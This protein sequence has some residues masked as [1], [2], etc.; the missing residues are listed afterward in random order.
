MLNH[1]FRLPAVGEPSIRLLAEEWINRIPAAAIPQQMRKEALKSVHG[2][3]QQLILTDPDCYPQPPPRTN[4][5]GPRNLH[6]LLN[7]LRDVQDRETVITR[8]E[9]AKACG[10]GWTHPGLNITQPHEKIDAALDSE[11]WMNAL[12]ELADSWGVWQ[13]T[14]T[15]TKRKRN[16]PLTP[17]DVCIRS[18]GLRLIKEVHAIR[19]LTC[20]INKKRS[21]AK[22]LDIRCFIPGNDDAKFQFLCQINV[23]A[24]ER[25][26]SLLNMTDPQ[27]RAQICLGIDI[28][29]L[30]H[31]DWTQGKFT[32]GQRVDIRIMN[33]ALDRACGKR[34]WIETIDDRHGGPAQVTVRLEEDDRSPVSCSARDIQATH[35][36][37]WSGWWVRGQN[38]AIVYQCIVCDHIHSRPTVRMTIRGPVC[39]DCQG[40]K[41]RKK[42]NLASRCPLS[43]PDSDSD[44]ESDEACD[45]DSTRSY[46]RPGVI[47]RTLIP[48][49][50]GTLMQ[51]TTVS[52]DEIRK[53]IRGMLQN[54][55]QPDWTQCWAT[56]K[57]VGFPLVSALDSDSSSELP[58]GGM[59]PQLHPCIAHFLREHGQKKHSGINSSQLDDFMS[60]WVH[61]EDMP[62]PNA[63]EAI[64]TCPCPWQQY[65]SPPEHRDP[66]YLPPFGPPPRSPQL[67]L[68]NPP[69]NGGIVVFK[70]PITHYLQTNSNQ[71]S[72]VEGIAW[73]RETDRTWSL[74]GARALPT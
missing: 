46:G 34:G 53:Y 26:Q 40:P 64:V 55:D 45:R 70:D 58:P 49:F 9:E 73:I 5:A 14:P 69:P 32:L 31:E 23:P 13:R 24:K 10:K 11:N 61:R 2:N 66:P 4:S 63:L 7:Q 21:N 59:E 52:V 17:S 19:P 29:W 50:I 3:G 36:P 60:R 27:L 6:I 39:R 12:K 22:T 71:I 25:L 20:Y 62:R 47:L 72:V 8:W 18:L 35:P 44:Y 65:T 51:D 1:L 16:A 33:Q 74:E 41:A 30:P 57:D 42:P 68:D 48:Q 15:S 43:D 67:L 28:L 38:E 54:Y 56:S 37:Q